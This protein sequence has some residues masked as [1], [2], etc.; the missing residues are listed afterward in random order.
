MPVIPFI[1]PGDKGS[2]SG[3]VRWEY[4]NIDAIISTSPTVGSDGTIYLGAENKKLYAINPDG[5]KKRD[6]LL[7]EIVYFTAFGSDGTIYVCGKC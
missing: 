5:T 4:N 1:F 3:K 6:I 2:P 7:G